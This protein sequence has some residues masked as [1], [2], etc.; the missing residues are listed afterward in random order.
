MIS[1]IIPVYNAEATLAV[2]LDSVL[3]QTLREFECILVDDGSTDGSGSI[4]DELA[5]TDPRFKVIHQ[6]NSGVS[7]ARNKGI[8]AASG[9]FVAFVDSDDFLEPRYLEA[10]VN[11]MEES[12]SDLVVCGMTVL[13]LDGSR[14]TSLPS[15]EMSFSL[16]GANAD[17]FVELERSNLLFAPFSKLYKKGLIE[18]GGIKFDVTKNYGEDL[19]FNL[20][21]WELASSIAAVPEALYTY[22]RGNDTL[23]TRFRQDM[24]SNDYGLWRLLVAFHSSKGLLGP[25]SNEFLYQKLWGI[26]YDGIFLFPRLGHA[27]LGYLEGLLGIPEIDDLKKYSGSFACAPWIKRWILHRRAVL[28]YFYF[29]YFRKK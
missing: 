26:V 14:V 4:C 16:E 9:D 12:G 17:R 28:F 1:V 21:Y 8:E 3:S 27:S 11:R 5:E 2:C 23:S 19:A 25:A 15:S 24:F 7:A 18:K 6:E 13:G 10:L 22:Q 29:N 20:N